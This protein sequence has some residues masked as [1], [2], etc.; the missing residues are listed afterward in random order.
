MAENGKPEHRRQTAQDIISQAKDSFNGQKMSPEQLEKARQKI[1]EQ[2][3]GDH[4]QE[5]AA[6]T[7]EMIKWL[8]DEWNARE[9][10][11]EQRVFSLSLATINFRQH[12]PEDKGG[13][14]KFDTVSKTAWQYYRDNSNQ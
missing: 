7:E 10:T 12:F 3:S 9:F 6:F 11:P 2:S 14:E 4:M 8:N 1:A 13:K 5:A